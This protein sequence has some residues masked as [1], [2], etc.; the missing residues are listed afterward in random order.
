MSNADASDTTYEACLLKFTGAV[1][2]RDQHPQE[3]EDL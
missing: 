3:E 1:S 2:S